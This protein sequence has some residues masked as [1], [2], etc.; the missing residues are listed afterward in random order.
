MTNHGRRQ[1]LKTAGLL[2]PA[3]A[4]PFLGYAAAREPGKLS[5]FHL[6]THEKLDIVY[7]EGTIYVPEALEE[8]DHLLRDFRSGEI[9]PID[10][11]LLDFLQAIQSQ[12]GR[13][14]SFEIIS[15]FR[16]SATNAMLRDQS[17]GVAKRSLHMQGKAIDVRMTDLSTKGLRKAALD[18]GFGGVGYYPKS[19]FVHLDT[20]RFRT[21]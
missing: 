10:P 21:W 16:S 7:R 3:L 5:F 20:G 1:L 19:N 18:L 14:G 13:D 2:M 6:H 9:H 12:T 17:L 11:H 8:I 4:L 15:G